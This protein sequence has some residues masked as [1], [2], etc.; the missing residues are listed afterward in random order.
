MQCNIKNRLACIAMAHGYIPIYYKSG[1]LDCQLAIVLMLWTTIGLM[2]V[3]ITRS[4]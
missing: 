1:D 3:T 4:V 2:G